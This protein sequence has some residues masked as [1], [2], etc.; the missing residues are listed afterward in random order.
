M[1][2]E[3]NNGFIEKN[4]GNRCLFGVRFNAS[5]SLNKTTLKNNYDRCNELKVQCIL[6]ESKANVYI[7]ECEII[8]HASKD[9]PY[10]SGLFGVNGNLTIIASKFENN[11][12]RI[13]NWANFSVSLNL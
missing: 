7:N 10:S 6:T 2:L 11:N 5:L 8:N 1:S 13:E 4:L 9:Y 12:T 3:Y